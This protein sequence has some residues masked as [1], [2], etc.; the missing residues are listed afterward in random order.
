MGRMWGLDGHPSEPALG[1]V[2][3]KGRPAMTVTGKTV[4]V[5]DPHNCYEFSF[6]R[7]RGGH[8][9]FTDL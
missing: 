4:L 6:F 7:L 3:L 2:G 9:F 1:G 5:F 8:S